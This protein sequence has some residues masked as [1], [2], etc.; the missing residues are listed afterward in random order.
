MGAGVS[1]ALSDLLSWRDGALTLDSDTLYSSLIGASW[2]VS[3]PLH[4][5]LHTC[6][7]S[8]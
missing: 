4:P 1:G 8:P 3:A 2:P 7:V 6:P 5:K